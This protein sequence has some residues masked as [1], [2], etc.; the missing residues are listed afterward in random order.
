MN[1]YTIRVPF[2]G[3]TAKDV[4]RQV[5]LEGGAREAALEGGGYLR[6]VSVDE[7]DVTLQGP[8]PEDEGAKPRTRTR[9]GKQAEAGP[10]EDE[11][12]REVPG[13]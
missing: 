12:V 10:A 5:L 8:W 7:N 4:G 2:D 9:R 6:F 3:Y 1:W 11:P 13:D